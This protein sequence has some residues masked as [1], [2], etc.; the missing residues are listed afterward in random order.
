MLTST[1]PVGFQHFRASAVLH[2]DHFAWE[3]CEMKA[4]SLLLLALWF[5]V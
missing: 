2:A 1:K 4:V 3:P 5:R